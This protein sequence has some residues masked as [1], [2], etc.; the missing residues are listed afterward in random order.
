MGIVWGFYREGSE[1]SRTGLTVEESYQLGQDSSWSKIQSHFFT[2]AHPPEPPS[3]R[4]G[5][6]DVGCQ[7]GYKTISVLD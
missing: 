3:T 5:H 2:R 6:K 7:R 4:I 1:A